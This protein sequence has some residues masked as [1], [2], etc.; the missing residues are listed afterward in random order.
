[1]G[2]SQAQT[3][4]IIRAAYES[5]IR[6]FD[7]GYSYQNGRSEEMIG[8]VLGDKPRDSFLVG[9]KSRYRYPLTNGF[10]EQLEREFSTSL[11][12]LKVDYVDIF[13]AHDCKS[14]EAVT[15]PRVIAAMT[16]I[17]ESGRAKLI[18]FSSHDQK[19]EIFQAGIDAGIYDVMIVSY[20]FK[21]DN[22][23]ETEAVI[24]RAA[25][26]G[27]GIF[28]MKSL[29]GGVA[30]ATTGEKIDAASCLKWIWQN[31]HIT[32]SLPGFSNYDELEEC[33]SAGHAP[34]LQPSEEQ[35]LSSLMANETLYCQHCDA[36]AGQCPQNLP[37]PDIMRAYMYTYGYHRPQMSK[38][39]LAD[40]GVPANACVECD[41]C[42]V[43]CRSGFDVGAKIAAIRPVVEVPDA[44][45]A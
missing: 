22:L 7:T 27:I 17:K 14:V 36:C 12:R 24:E 6:Y 35:Y 40:L 26:A 23:K 39:V 11:Q 2:V 32:T 9:T 25:Q 30:N 29:C 18:G 4:N 3:P 8:Q 38:A 31:P 15:D 33:L 19:P 45:L 34:E 44:F 43:Q 20:N 41:S 16:K 13:F 1:M 42:T 10:E 37:I 21:L 5:G 28:T